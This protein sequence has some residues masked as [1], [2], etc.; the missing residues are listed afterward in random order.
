MATTQSVARFQKR[1][2]ASAAF[3]GGASRTKIAAATIRRARHRRQEVQS[4]RIEQ[5]ARAMLHGEGVAVPGLKG[6][7]EPRQP[8][9]GK[10]P[11]LR[12]RRKEHECGEHRQRLGGEIVAEA[13][14][15]Q[16]CGDCRKASVAF[17]ASDMSDV[18]STSQPSSAKSAAA[19]L[20]RTR[21]KQRPSIASASP[22]PT[23]FSPCGAT[24]QMNNDAPNA[25]NSA[26]TN[27]PRSNGSSR[28]VSPRSNM[29]AP[30][31]GTT[32]RQ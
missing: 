4:F 29:A 7:R 11:S 30:S 3:F 21:R 12:P 24:S 8:H 22:A 16:H 18:S 25:E 10:P 26:A 14:F 2:S 19:R 32:D 27:A 9:G 23:S 1:L 5:E 13:R 31:V 28:F 15:E 17:A 6:K 20:A